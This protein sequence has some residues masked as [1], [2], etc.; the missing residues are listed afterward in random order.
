MN[1]GHESLLCSLVSLE[2]DEYSV[3]R[4]SK[5]HRRRGMV[6][7]MRGAKPPGVEE[8]SGWRDAI[9]LMKIDVRRFR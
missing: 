8:Y 6:D 1:T 9:R 3:E 7:G 2:A 5:W 4:I